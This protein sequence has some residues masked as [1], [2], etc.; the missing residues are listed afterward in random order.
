MCARLYVCVYKA[1]TW[2]KNEIDVFWLLPMSVVFF[3]VVCLFIEFHFVELVFLQILHYNQLEI[4]IIPIK[5]IVF[6]NSIYCF[7]EIEFN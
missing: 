3:G 7:Y 1:A 6:A 4:T 5:S 2:A